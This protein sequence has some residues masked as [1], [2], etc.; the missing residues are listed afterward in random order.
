MCAQ[1]QG[2]GQCFLQC[3][4]C[5]KGCSRGGCCATVAV[6]SDSEDEEAGGCCGCFGDV[7]VAGSASAVVKSSAKG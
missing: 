2:C 7:P 6:N 3:G 5:F 4:G 1:I